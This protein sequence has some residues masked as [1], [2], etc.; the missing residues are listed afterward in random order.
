MQI[1]YKRLDELNPYERNPRKNDKAVAGVVASIKEF[2]FKV[3]MVV[4]SSGTIVCGHTRYKAAK[5]LGMNEVPCIIA[6]DLTE[7]QI[8]AFRLA[9]NKVSEA[10]EWDFDLLDTEMG[11]IVGIDMTDF[12]FIDT[13]DIDWADVEELSEETYDKPE[14]DMCKCPECG[15]IGNKNSFVKVTSSEAEAQ[16]E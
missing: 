15:Y 16:G 2:G 11:D 8:K 9:D 10:A 13:P 5:E 4:D 6:D 1:I 7:E 3:P 14:K 12:G